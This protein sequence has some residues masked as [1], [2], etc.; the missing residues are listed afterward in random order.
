[1]KIKVIRLDKIDELLEEY[2]E[3]K[4]KGETFSQ[5]IEVSKLIEKD[6]NLFDW[7]EVEEENLIGVKE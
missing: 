6:Y 2:K 1:M 5:F 3:F 4:N 7:E